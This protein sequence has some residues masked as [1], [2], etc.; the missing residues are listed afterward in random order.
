LPNMTANTFYVGTTSHYLTRVSNNMYITAPSLVALQTGGTSRVNVRSS[1][2]ELVNVDLDISTAGKGLIFDDVTAGKVPVSNG[3][4]YVPGTVASID[5]FSVH[6]HNLSYS[7][8]TSSDYTSGA[9]RWWIP[10]YDD[11]KNFNIIGYVEGKS[12]T[13][14]SAKADSPTDAPN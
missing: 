7:P 12:H 9:F 6:T 13:H 14:V 3:V 5:G 4:R 11:I 8:Q 1:T 10:V 2:L